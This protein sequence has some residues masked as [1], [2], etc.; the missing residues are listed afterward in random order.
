MPGE[1]LSESARR[2]SRIVRAFTDSQRRQAGAAKKALQSVH[3]MSASVSSLMLAGL[4]AHVSVS[5]A[6]AWEE[7]PEQRSADAITITL[8]G[9][10]RRVPSAGPYDGPFVEPGEGIAI[11]EIL[12]ELRGMEI[13]IDGVLL[14]LG[15]SSSEF[16]DLGLK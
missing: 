3:A 14:T 10:Q 12:R 6:A 1:D 5:T 13:T 11:E 9:R 16:G 15:N 4:T 7:I 2:I 8:Q